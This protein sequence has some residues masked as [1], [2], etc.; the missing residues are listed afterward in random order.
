MFETGPIQLHRRPDQFPVLLHGVVGMPGSERVLLHRRQDDVP[1]ALQGGVGMFEGG[2][3]PLH[4]R[5]DVVPVQFQGI[6]L[7]LE[8]PP[9]LLHRRQDDF[10]VLPPSGTNKFEVVPTQSNL[11]EHRLTSFGRQCLHGDL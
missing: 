6:A 5:Q 7:I 8:S 2:S 10:P 3:S 9:V 11:G 1:V 4:R